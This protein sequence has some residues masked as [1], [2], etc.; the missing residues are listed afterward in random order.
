MIQVEN[1][2]TET[3]MACFDL[4]GVH[5]HHADHGHREQS[6]AGLDH[7]LRRPAHE[8]VHALSQAAANGVTDI[9]SDQRHPG[10]PPRP[11]QQ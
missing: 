6:A 9:P 10:G 4:G 7:H 11:L 8:A 2:G 1:N 3:N 5:D